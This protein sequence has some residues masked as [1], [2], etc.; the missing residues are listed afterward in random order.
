MASVIYF[1][2]GSSSGIGGVDTTGQLGGPLA[3]STA[4]RYPD[5][6]SVSQAPKNFFGN[7]C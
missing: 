4:I 3:T 1:S 5:L 2:I 6:S 7:P